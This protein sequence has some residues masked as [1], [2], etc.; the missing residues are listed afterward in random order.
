MNSVL[1]CLVNTP[2]LARY[3]I[4]G[5]YEKNL[6]NTTVNTN[7][8]R[9]YL[10]NEFAFIMK[11][12]SSGTYRSVSPIDFKLALGSIAQRF[13]TYEQQDSHEVLLIVLDGLH[14]DVNKVCCFLRTREGIIRR[15][16]SW[17]VVKA[18]ES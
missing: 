4:T 8:K 1:Q 13:L 2:P 18:L 14:N 11:V 17:L 6:N 7:T 16:Q 9:G 10:A 3:F 12:L 5:S 15:F